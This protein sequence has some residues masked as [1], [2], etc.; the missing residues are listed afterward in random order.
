M[1]TNSELLGLDGDYPESALPLLIR[2]DGMA[3][4]HEDH[5]RILDRRA[6]PFERRQIECFEVEEVARAIEGMAIQGAFT[7]AIAAGYGLAL[8]TRDGRCDDSALES[9]RLG[10]NRLLRTRPTGLALGRMLV[11]AEQAAEKAIADGSPA[12]P[13]IV[14]VVE[15]AA[16][17]LA[18]QALL[19]G[20][21]ANA[22][23]QDGA[24]ILTHC[25]ADRAFLYFLMEAN[26]TGKR[27]NVI[28]T[29]TRPYGQGARLTAPSVIEAGHAA[30]LVTDGMPGALM[31]GGD[32]DAVF[33]ASD[34]VCLDGSICNK[35]GTYLYALAA[36]DNRI[37]YYALRQSGPDPESKGAAAVEIEY[38]DPDSVLV[39]D[40]RRV[41]IE[42][43]DAL[44][45]AFDITPPQYVAGVVTDRGF[46]EA[47]EIHT[48][49]DRP[50][51]VPEALL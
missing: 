51:A 4:W 1:D 41:T 49:L 15:R 20:R 25:F 43:V 29:E 32:V 36:W 12:T 50:A 2:R 17:A 44:Y 8:T 13:A 26:R 35:V 11:A 30:T 40:G 42:G 10:K 16:R 24:N 22:L 18:R 28:C 27:F 21:H 47:G 3:S 19:T 5:V 6:L 7:L 14:G 23:M 46:F 45:P 39:S 37:P 9:V 38:R 33:T 31:S 34:R 48:Y